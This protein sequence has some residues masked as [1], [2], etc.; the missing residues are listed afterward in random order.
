MHT[1]THENTIQKAH[2]NRFE[3]RIAIIGHQG[4]VKTAPYLLFWG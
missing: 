2:K 1:I 3:Y 4:H